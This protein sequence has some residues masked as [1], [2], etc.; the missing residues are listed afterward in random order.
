MYLLAGTRTESAYKRENQTVRIGRVAVGRLPIGH[1]MVAKMLVMALAMV[2][3][4]QR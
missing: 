2:L 1:T 3:V 4:L